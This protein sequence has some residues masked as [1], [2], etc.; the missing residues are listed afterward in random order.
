M[1]GRLSEEGLRISSGQAQLSGYEICG[2]GL[3]ALNFGSGM[4]V[5][6]G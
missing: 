5:F 2:L 3:H 1:V 6:S 4:V